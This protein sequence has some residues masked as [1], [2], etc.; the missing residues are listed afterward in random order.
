MIQGHYE[1]IMYNSCVDIWT[2]I[3]S[4]SQI[5]KATTRHTVQVTK[6][7]VNVVVDSPDGAF[8]YSRDSPSDSP[9]GAAY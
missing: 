6:I 5:I 8:V 3:H 9:D 7:N 1:L 4:G 2:G